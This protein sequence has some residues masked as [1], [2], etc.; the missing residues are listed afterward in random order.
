MSNR[1]YQITVNDLNVDVVRKN[2]KHMH[3]AVHTA[4]GRVRVSVPLRVKDEAVRVAVVSKMPWIRR[5]QR[6]LTGQERQSPKK[7]I[8]GESHYFRGNRYLLHVVYRDAPPKVA[9]NEKKTI[10][11]FVRT[12]SDAAKRER[13][14]LEWYRKQLKEIA[15]PLIAKW[16]EIIGVE[17]VEWRI[18]RMKTRWGTCNIRARRIWLNLELAKW[19]IHC[20]EYIIIHEL[21]HL[22]ERLHNDQFV[23]HMDKFMPQWRLVRDELN[24]GPLG[25]GE[26]EY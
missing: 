15:P 9:I 7:F 6:K 16:E 25:H 14:M 23:A 21:V 10:D 1:N 3:L 5:Q 12:G 17:I 22:I 18:K 11:M 20:L 4:D 8:S 26:W 24:R 19:P 13:V 2:I